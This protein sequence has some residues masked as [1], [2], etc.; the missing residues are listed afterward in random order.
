MTL[1]LLFGF[2]SGFAFTLLYHVLREWIQKN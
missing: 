2:I 1:S